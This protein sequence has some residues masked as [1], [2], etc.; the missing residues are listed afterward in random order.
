MAERYYNSRKSNLDKQGEPD[1]HWL[2]RVRLKRIVEE[3]GFEVLHFLPEESKSKFPVLSVVFSPFDFKYNKKFDIVAVK[4]LSN[5]IKYRLIVEI[6]GSIHEK[7]RQQNR[8]SYAK[9]IVE[10]LFG[11]IFFQRIDKQFVLDSSDDEIIKELGLDF[12][13]KYKNII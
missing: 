8:D 2:A 4:K 13:I 5:G 9:E 1:L 3:L 10:V 12:L 6:D 7:P 11:N